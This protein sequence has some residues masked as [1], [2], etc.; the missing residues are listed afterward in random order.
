MNVLKIVENEQ[1]MAYQ[2]EWRSDIKNS[3]FDHGRSLKQVIIQC[4]I[5]CS[6][7]FKLLEK[8]KNMFNSN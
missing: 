5:V 3:T 2:C 8:V 4:Y 1:Y 7:C 6:L